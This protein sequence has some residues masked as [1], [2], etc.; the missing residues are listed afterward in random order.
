MKRLGLAFF[1]FLLALPAWGQVPNFPQT[2]P[3]NSVVGRL[4]ISS[5]PSQA[6]P[7]AQL[8]SN[9]GG[10]PSTRNINTTAPL[11]GGGNL[12]V[13]R[14]LSITTN[15]IDNTL[16]RQSAALSLVGRSANST[17]NVADISA[18]AGSSCAFIE[19][20]ST[21]IC[22]QLATAGISN[23]AVD[24]TKIRQS[25]ALSLVGRS[26]NSTGNVADIS[27]VAGSS[28]AFIESGSTLICGQLATA[29]IANN[30]VTLAKLATQA[31]NTTLSNATSGAA[32]PT[33]FA[34]P[35]CSTSASALNWTTNTG[36]G[37]NSAISAAVANLTGLGTGVATTLG[38]NLGS[39]GAIVTVNGALGT[40]SSG[41]GTNL[42]GVPI[43]TGV[44]GLGTG[45]GTFLGTP[46][47]ANLNTT[48]GVTLTQTIAS[49]SLA[50]ATGAIASGACTSA[51]TAA[52]TG[53]ATTDRILLVFNADPTATTGYIPL[54]MLTIVPY[55][56]LNTVNIKACNNTSGTIT[57]S[58]VTVNWSVL[59]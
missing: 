16:I 25:A 48:L 5:G 28:C 1:A 2:L 15:G 9:I 31:A 40:P 53:T 23:N 13:D 39:G 35:S 49:G 27:A 42:T 51:Q 55:P 34:M 44:S 19:S 32:V 43:S 21:V 57:P 8:L 6:I 18:V 24:N 30:A 4:G 10:V 26:A 14:T 17:G 59:R 20:G 41:V 3:Q 37:C 12:T 11:A 50:L 22:G 7:F 38:V 56:T 58:P 33:A 45:V 46:T 54:S 52:A 29:G 47:P 36:F